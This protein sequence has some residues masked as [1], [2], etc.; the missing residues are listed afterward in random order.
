LVTLGNILFKSI[1]GKAI[2]VNF[3]PKKYLEVMQRFYFSPSKENL[4][5][6][7]SLYNPTNATNKIHANIDVALEKPILRKCSDY[8]LTILRFQCPLT[9]IFPPYSLAS[10]E[11][12]VIISTATKM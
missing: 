3:P 11:F 6:N 9:T 2:E 10:T 1:L 4:I 12:K 5:A 7:L 8:K